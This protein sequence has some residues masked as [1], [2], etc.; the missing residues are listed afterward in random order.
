LSQASRPVELDGELYERIC[1]AVKP[2]DEIT[3]LSNKHVNRIAS[4]GRSGVFVETARSDARG[5]GPQL[6][7]A[8]MIETAWDHLR[9]RG[10]LSH[11]ELLNALNVKRS[12][13]VCAL[14]ALFPDVVVRSTRPTVLELVGSREPGAP[15]RSV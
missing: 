1:S 14:L 2:G 4:L 10:E 5:T 6:V 8:W 13:F 7:P 12:A 15:S 9:R 11:K 3:T